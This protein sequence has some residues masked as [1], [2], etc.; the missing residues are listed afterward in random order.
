MNFPKRTLLIPWPWWLLITAIMWFFGCNTPAPEQAQDALT[1]VFP[2]KMSGLNEPLPDSVVAEYEELFEPVVR[3]FGLNGSVAVAW[4]GKVL[5]QHL[6]GYSDI[7]QRTPLTPNTLFQLAS[8]SKMFTAMAVMMLQEEGKI[9]YDSTVIS[10]IPE[11]PYHE[12][13]I[14]H[15]L[16]HTSG[17]PKY[18]FFVDHYWDKS[19]PL[20]NPDLIRIMKQEGLSLYARPGHRYL[21]SNT[22]YAMLA[23]LVERVS[24]M[25]FSSFLEHK[26]FRPLHMLHTRTAD[27][28]TGTD[29]LDIARGFNGSSRR[30]IRYAPDICDSVLG[31]KGVFSTAAD[32]IKWYRALVFG[33]LV[34]PETW[35]EAITGCQNARGV[36]IHYGFGLRLKKLANEILYYHNGNWNGFTSSFIVR[37]NESFCVIVLNN[38]RQQASALANRLVQVFMKH[39]GADSKE[40]DDLDEQ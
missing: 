25:P 32:L 24:G 4:Q 29:T 34:S 22:G 12:V 19:Q 3:R 10:Y 36:D 39:K 2:A 1:E 11:F 30:A 21:Y 18:T 26:I 9:C 7:H 8:V 40:I 38:T 37:P 33:A 28:L 13:T 17:L 20:S 23:L 14:R 16:H 15:L 6:Q 35:S 31:D 27:Q 5:Y